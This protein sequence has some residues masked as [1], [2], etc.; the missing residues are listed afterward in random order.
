MYSKTG[1]D[2]DAHWTKTTHKK[3]HNNKKK[4]INNNYSITPRI[5]VDQVLKYNFL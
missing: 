5:I 2:A 3:R 1:P 4:V